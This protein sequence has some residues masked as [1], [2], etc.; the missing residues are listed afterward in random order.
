MNENWTD[1]PRES[2]LERL[3]SK[4]IP[5]KVSFSIEENSLG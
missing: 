1:G 5:I 4:T 3:H 2:E